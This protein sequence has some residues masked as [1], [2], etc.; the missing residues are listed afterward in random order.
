MKKLHGIRGEKC[1][2][3]SISVP[4]LEFTF[5]PAPFPL[6]GKN[7]YLECM[8]SQRKIRVRIALLL[9][10]L[11][12]ISAPCFAQRVAIDGLFADWDSLSV[13]AADP[14]GDAGSSGVDF[15]SLQVDDD[16]EW[17][18][19]AF[20]TGVDLLLQDGNSITLAIDTDADP[21]T[22]TKIR[23]IGAE[24]FWQ[25]GDREGG[26]QLGGI[27][28]VR[29]ND[30]RIITAPSMTSSRFEMALRRGTVVDGQPLFP[31]DSIRLALSDAAGDVL[32]NTTGGVAYAFRSAGV[33]PVVERLIRT[34]DA[35]SLRLL[36]WNTL[37]NG[38]LQAPRQPA[39]TR[40]LRALRPD[41]MCFQ[42]CFDVSAAEVLA[43][44][45]TVIDP[46]SGRSWHALK[47]DAGD[48][49]V[50][51]LE[52]EDSWLLQSEYRESAYLLRTEADERLLLLNCHFRCC[53]A[54]NHRQREADGVI[55]FL[56]DA[57]TPGGTVTV[58]EGTPF[59]LVGDLNL[60]GDY[61]QYE[62]LVTGD[63][64]NN[65][66]FGA[67]EAPDWDGGSWAE[68]EARHP[69]S[70][71]NFT[72]DDGE[73]SYSPGKLDYI[74][75]TASAVDIT[76]DMVVDPRE[77]S[78]GQ[79]LRLGIEIND[80]A[81]ASD[82]LPR[83]AD[84]RWKKADAVEAVA[85]GA[86]HIGAVYPQPAHRTV[87]VEVRADRPLALQYFL[88]D[89]LGRRIALSNRG[90]DTGGNAAP[91][92]LTL[93]DLHPGVYFLLIT[94]GIRKEYRPIVVE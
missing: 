55:R 13:L 64:V 37:F 24:I 4:V 6:P 12:G 1:L 77:I 61:R 42:E 14:S 94:D 91:R 92:S 26:V 21:A 75:Y 80:A 79:R 90:E 45:Q 48:I 93:P 59:V 46:P 35:G 68:L 72:W 89:V 33:M 43:F 15:T 25:F 44:I 76:Q 28:Q 63:I 85:P 18:Y 49:L 82:H 52:V 32:P 11:A 60:V 54:D 86:W 81:I 9:L 69:S 29:Q 16:V 31:S 74:L 65:A 57:K 27:T 53:A 22:G 71:F 83:F 87:S 23:G 58:P 34:P 70:L 84:L 41:I 66:A 67:D 73:S 7:V 40:I 47:R 20:D 50:T 88:H 19:L 36:T 39:Y 10:L 62:T 56:R 8:N 17:L 30:I 78:P 3:G 38:L 5:F 2:P 51:H